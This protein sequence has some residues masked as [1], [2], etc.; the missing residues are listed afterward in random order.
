MPWPDAELQLD[1]GE[2]EL[3][4]AQLLHAAWPAL[5]PVLGTAEFFFNNRTFMRSCVFERVDK[6]PRQLLTGDAHTHGLTMS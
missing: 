1:G 3:Q 5:W 4:A 2:L 6:S